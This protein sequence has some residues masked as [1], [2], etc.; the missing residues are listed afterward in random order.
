MFSSAGRASA[1]QAEGREFDPPNTH[2]MFI[3]FHNAVFKINK[4][5]G[6][7]RVDLNNLKAPSK[8]FEEFIKKTKRV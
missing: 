4:Y 6:T 5:G 8:E 2:Q 3:Q 1:C 7:Q